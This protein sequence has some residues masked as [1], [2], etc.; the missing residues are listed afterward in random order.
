[1]IVLR[2]TAARVTTRR[3]LLLSLSNRHF[4][5]QMPPILHTALVSSFDWIDKPIAC[6]MPKAAEEGGVAWRVEDMQVTRHYLRTEQ[7]TEFGYSHID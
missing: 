5:N 1:M 6:L 3:R 7:R 4:A 2:V